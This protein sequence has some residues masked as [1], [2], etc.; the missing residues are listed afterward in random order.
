MLAADPDGRSL[1]VTTAYRLDAEPP[2]DKALYSS[3]LR[4]R[5]RL[6]SKETPQLALGLILGVAFALSL[7]LGLASGLSLRLGLAV[8]L[9]LGQVLN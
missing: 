6:P 4:V 3:C 7:S 5:C 2:V 9:S 8:A 1:Y